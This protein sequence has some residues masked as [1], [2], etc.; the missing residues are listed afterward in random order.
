MNQAKKGKEVKTP[1][2]KIPRP[3]LPFP[4]WMKKKIKDDKFNNFMTMLKLLL[5]NIPLIEA[6][7]KML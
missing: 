6:L 1:L 3:P 4:Y 5:V 2:T 7:E